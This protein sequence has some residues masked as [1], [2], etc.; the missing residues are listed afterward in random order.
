MDV[1]T[2][3]LNDILRKEVYVR[4]PDGFVD[5]D[6]LNHVYKL[7]NSL[8]GLKQAPRTRRST[9]GCMQLLGD[10]LVSWSSKRQKSATISSKKAEYIALSGYCAQVLWMRSQ[11][12]DYGL[13]F[14]K[15]IIFHF[16]KEKVENGVVELYFVNS[17][18]QPADVFTKAL[19]RDRIE[20]LINKLGMRDPPFKE[21]ILAFI[22]TF[23]YSRDIKSFSDVK[24][25]ILHQPWRTFGTII[26][27]CLSGKVTGLDQLRLS[28]AQI[29]WGENEGT[30]VSPGVL[31]VP[32]YGSE[33]EQISWKSSDEEN[34]DEVSMSKDDDDYANN[35]DDDDQDDDNEQTK[36]YNDG[37]DSVHPKFLTH[38]EED[39][40]EECS[41]LRVYTPS[42]F[43]STDDEAYDEVTHGD[44]FEEQ[45][46][47]EE[48]TN[49]E[50]E[51][52]E[53]YN[54]VNINLEVRDAEMTD[55]LLANVQTTEVIEDTH[56]IITAVTPEVQQQSSSVSSGFIS[57]MLN[58]NPDT[59]IDFILNLIIESTYLVDVPVTTNDEIPL[60]SITTLPPPPIPLIQPVQQ[61]PVSTPTIA[62]NIL[63]TYGDIVTLKRR[64]YDEDEDDEPSA[65][66]NR[67]SKRTKA[68]KE[69]ESTSAP[70]DN[71]SK[72]IDS[73]KEGSKFKTRST[74][75]SDQAEEQVH[76]VKDLEEPTHQKF[77]TS[78]TDD[79]YVDETTQLPDWFQIP[80]KP[81]SP[82]CDWNKTSHANHGPIQ[83]WISTLARNEDPREIISRSNIRVN[84]RLVQESVELEY[85]LE[86][87][88]KA[89]TDQLDWNNPKG[90]EYPHDLRKPLPLIPN[91]RGRRVIPFDHFISNDLADDDKLYTFKEGDYNRICLQDIE[92]MLFLLVQGKLTNLNIKER[93]ALGV[94]LRMFTKSIVIKRRVED[95]QL[96]IESYQKKL[97]LTKPDTY[98]S[99]LKR[100]TTYTA[101]SNPKGFI[102][103]NQDKKNRLM[104]IDELHKFSDGT[105]NG[106][107]SALDDTLKRI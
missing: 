5:Q 64:R 73:S 97:N 33:D 38:D 92:D 86:E 62:P 45:K 47:D 98:K 77:E 18:Y 83:P 12:I 100:K 9:S 27:K 28:R 37:D 85:L 13:G 50:E 17:E 89:T 16:I 66:S 53:M 102:Y 20:F 69:P 70:K 32:T 25:D 93:L 21:Q 81:P 22:R 30:S 103:Q 104:C 67:G 44:N 87:V 56:V 7:K 2:V 105:L 90:Q 60:S 82:D 72:S 11:L 99:D 96:G 94:S 91:S 106:V 68:G 65:R 42:H 80:V 3:F 23:G 101:Y 95:L 57:K 24:V 1:K 14:N 48:K 58:P 40:E 75:K 88:Y 10:R 63:A 15:V 43:E 52:N 35:E 8:Y 78:F 79:H 6:N 84:K 31:D 36:S 4:Q 51:V 34:D 26:N 41:E 49:E 107:R 19:G 39:K 71:T 76:I 54:D 29:I 61:T 59:S 46:L 74:G 55:D